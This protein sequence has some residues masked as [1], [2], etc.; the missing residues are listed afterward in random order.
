MT[1][2]LPLWFPLAWVY[3]KLVTELYRVNPDDDSARGGV[4]S[5]TLDRF[6]GQDTEGTCKRYVVGWGGGEGEAVGR[7]DGLNGI[8]LSRVAKHNLRMVPGQI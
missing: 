6:K 1:T 5:E 3:G 4:C 7:G 2:P 8:R